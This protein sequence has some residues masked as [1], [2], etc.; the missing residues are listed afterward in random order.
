MQKSQEDIRT[1]A[2]NSSLSDIICALHFCDICKLKA[3]KAC[4]HI[5]PPHFLFFT[6]SKQHI[7]QEGLEREE[8][9]FLLTEKDK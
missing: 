3:T 6:E 9:Q 5:K 8:T 2:A 1:R 4:E 7:F